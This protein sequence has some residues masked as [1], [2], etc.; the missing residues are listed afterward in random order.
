MVAGLVRLS[1]SKNLCA[2]ATTS[3]KPRELD[4]STTYNTPSVGI[5]HP[6]GCCYV[7]ASP[8][9]SLKGARRT[10]VVQIWC[11]ETAFKILLLQQY[12]LL[13]TWAH[14][15]PRTQKRR[16]RLFFFCAIFIDCIFALHVCISLFYQLL[17]LT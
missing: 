5:R 4:L 16:Q 7:D 17:C 3:S 6:F 9:K 11:G 13:Y 1:S 15:Q 14:Y 2:T 8:S 10:V 12:T